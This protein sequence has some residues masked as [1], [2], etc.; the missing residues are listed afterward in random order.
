MWNYLRLKH[1]QSPIQQQLA[2]RQPHLTQTQPMHSKHAHVNKHTRAHTTVQSNTS[3][4]CI[5]R[6]NLLLLIIIHNSYVLEIP[7]VIL[8]RDKIQ[9]HLSHYDIWQPSDEGEV[10]E[11]NAAPSRQVCTGLVNEN[12]FF[13]YELHG[14]LMAWLGLA[15]MFDYG[16]SSESS[17]R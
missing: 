11:K 14:R 3:C 4:S 1:T 12:R 15:F 2:A 6:N 13:G 16:W 7:Y 10:K 9:W 5:T 17:G 8:C